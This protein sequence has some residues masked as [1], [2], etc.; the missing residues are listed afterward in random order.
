MESFAGAPGPFDPLADVVPRVLPRH[1]L[2]D[3]LAALHE[4]AGRRASA[5]AG[6][7]T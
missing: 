5:C 1:V 7:T 2:V 3:D 6:T 4:D